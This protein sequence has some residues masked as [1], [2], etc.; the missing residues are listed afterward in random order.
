MITK[1]RID[2]L[3][4]HLAKL[5]SIGLCR[6]VK[7]R[8]A[9]RCDRRK[10]FRCIRVTIKAA[11]ELINKIADKLEAMFEEQDIPIRFDDARKTNPPKATAIIL[12]HLAP[13][14]KEWERDLSEAATDVRRYKNNAEQ[15]WKALESINKSAPLTQEQRESLGGYV[16]EYLR[17]GVQGVW[18]DLAEGI[19]ALMKHEQSQQKELDEAR[20]IIER[21]QKGCECDSKKPCSQCAKA[22]SWLARN[23]GGE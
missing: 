2:E 1:E 14:Q 6:M 16:T 19:A 13:V 4:I 23:G 21:W 18:W 7:D 8:A 3:G 5:D 11:E 12:R 20:E 15:A 10:G 9:W 22:Q 17:R